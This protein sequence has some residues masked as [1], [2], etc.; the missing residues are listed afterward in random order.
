M[1]SIKNQDTHSQIE[2]HETK[3]AEYPNESHLGGSEINKTSTVPNFMSNILPCIKI[4]ESPNSLNSKQRKVINVVH[5]WVTNYI[6]YNGHNAESVHIFL[7]GSGDTDKSN[8]EK[9]IYSSILKILP[10]H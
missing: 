1:T 10:Y 5:K 8:L 6:K 3:R 4:K 2:N 9:A 7:S